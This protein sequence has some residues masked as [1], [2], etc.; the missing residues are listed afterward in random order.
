MLQAS[1]PNVLLLIATSNSHSVQF[2][3]L[4][5]I[6]CSVRHWQIAIVICWLG[7]DNDFCFLCLQKTSTRH[8]QVLDVSCREWFW[9][10]VISQLDVAA[11]FPYEVGQRAPKV[12][13]PGFTQVPSNIATTPR[14]WS[15]NSA[16]CLPLSLISDTTSFRCCWMWRDH[17]PCC[18][19][20]AQTLLFLL[21]LA[22]WV[23]QWP[24][25]LSL[26]TSATGTS[27]LTLSNYLRKVFLLLKRWKKREGNFQEFSEVLL[28]RRRKSALF[29]ASHPLS[30]RKLFVNFLSR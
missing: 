14:L 19:V 16:Y 28:F 10:F 21:C 13:V 25:G 29:C 17:T 27:C 7:C 22:Y 30:C 4:S 18:K 23:W 6:E 3:F 15:G 24:L 11:W 5:W 1:S 9:V 2:A 26:L 12:F 8:F 20:L